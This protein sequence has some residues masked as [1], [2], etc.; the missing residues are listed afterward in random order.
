M[1][2]SFSKEN[3]IPV[4]VVLKAMRATMSSFDVAIQRSRFDFKVA[5]A[6]K[7][8]EEHITN[9]LSLRSVI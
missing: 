7:L 8:N 3:K 5:N 6:I 1:S 4:L 9:Y 2:N